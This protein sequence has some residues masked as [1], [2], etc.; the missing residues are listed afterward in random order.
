[1]DP[2]ARDRLTTL[3]LAEPTSELTGSEQLFSLL[4]EE[5]R[6]MAGSYMRR[7]RPDHTLRPTALVHE[8]YLRLIHQDQ[9][10]WQG[11]AHFLAIAARVMR[12]ILVD[13]ARG[14]T[15]IKRGGGRTRV[16]LDENLA[17]SSPTSCD[18][19][20]LHAALDRLAKEDGRSAQVVELR[21]FGGLTAREAA[22]VLGMSK[23]TVDDD[24][25]FA[26]L[27][28]SRDLAGGTT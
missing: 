13:H 8:A 2:S 15:A 23:R 9:V 12:Q 4:Y 22:H 14:K 26:R 28:L 27:W 5:L 16:T 21:L 3:L 20:D 17:G 18:V 7:E 19:L 10:T 11:K 25:K 1:M 6:D 24:W